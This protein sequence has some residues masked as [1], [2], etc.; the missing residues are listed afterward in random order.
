MSKRAGSQAL[1]TF[2]AISLRTP[3]A[4]EC[5]LRRA[6]TLPPALFTFKEISL[7]VFSSLCLLFSSPA[8]AAD[9]PLVEP[10]KAAL[11]AEQLD[12]AVAAGEKAVKE[13]PENAEA[14]LWLGRAYGQKAI[15]AS[16]FSQLGWAKK[17]KASFEKAVVLDPK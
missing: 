5:A 14:H 9:S 10:V 7:F 1:F 3:L 4:R 13:Q 11:K 2:K 17:C 12:A 8:F 15:K 16:L 6:A